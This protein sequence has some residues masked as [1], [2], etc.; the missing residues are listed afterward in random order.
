MAGYYADSSVFLTTAAQSEGLLVD[1]PN[2]YPW[3]PAILICLDRL[4][5]NSQAGIKST[6]KRTGKYL[7][8]GFQPV[9]YTSQRF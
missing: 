5:I 6:L 1:N 9:L 3:M 8:T 2:H 4:G 7:A